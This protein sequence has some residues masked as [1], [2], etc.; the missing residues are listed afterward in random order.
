MHGMRF[1]NSVPPAQTVPWAL[2]RPG[3]SRTRSANMA[4]SPVRQEYIFSLVTVPDP[5][6]M[7]EPMPTPWL[8][9]G[10]PPAGPG[11]EAAKPTP[12]PVWAAK[13]KGAAAILKSQRRVQSGRLI[14]LCLLSLGAAAAAVAAVAAVGQDKL[15]AQYAVLNAPALNLLPV[16]GAGTV[17]F[18]S[19]QRFCLVSRQAAILLSSC[20]DGRWPWA[21][22]PPMLGPL[23]V[24]GVVIRGGHVGRSHVCPG[25]Y[26]C[27]HWGFQWAS[28]IA[29]V[30][31]RAVTSSMRVT[32]PPPTALF[33]SP[34]GR[35][36]LPP[37][38]YT[39]GF[40]V[41][42]LN[43]HWADVEPSPGAF[44]PLPLSV[45]DTAVQRAAAAGLAVVLTPVF[46]FG[47]EG[48][49]YYPT[50]AVGLGGDSVTVVQRSA[51]PFVTM[52][53]QRYEG[54]PAVVGCVRGSICCS[55]RS[56]CAC[57]CVV[58]VIRVLCV[59][60][61]V[62]VCV[63]VLVCALCVVCVLRAS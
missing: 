29:A 13:G 26:S 4:Q 37:Q 27:R 5:E 34:G 24:A 9:P 40:R 2:T 11:A 46:N 42:R 10:V 54:Q 57:L 63:F 22:P 18:L 45:L 33:L 47:S 48:M 43:L 23:L 7:P 59:C 60:V 62:C 30:T 20:V 21:C 1:A 31:G 14:A 25:A 36:Q 16:S 19:F 38:I 44:D 28:N 49:D 53:A 58:C 51:A 6:P 3:S 15:A 12:A 61:R 41:L 35:L 55:A 50:W 32:P 56:L 39:K 8:G 17:T 52:I